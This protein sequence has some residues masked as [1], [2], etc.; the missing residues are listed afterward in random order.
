MPS[1]YYYFGGYDMKTK[2]LTVLMVE[3]GQHPSLY[4][5]KTGVVTI[6]G[7]TIENG[8]AANNGNNAHLTGNGKH[9]GI[10]NN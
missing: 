6:S 9:S 4:V 8:A 2:E 1:G 10:R 7:A 5:A 3:P